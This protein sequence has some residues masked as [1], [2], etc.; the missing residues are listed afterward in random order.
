M[1]NLLEESGVDSVK[2]LRH[3]V[4]AN[5]HSTL[6]ETNDQRSIAHRAPSL[7]QVEAWIAEAKTLAE[8]RTVAID[9]R[10]PI[11]AETAGRHTAARRA[12]AMH[13][14]RTEGETA[15]A[16]T[17]LPFLPLEKVNR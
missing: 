2:E 10:R 13:G 1:A 16:S 5:L 8:E 7:A 9:E 4:P 14:E 11:G 15:G 17:R 3:R 6:S 12:D